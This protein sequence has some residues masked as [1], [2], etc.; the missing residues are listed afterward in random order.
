MI[1][2]RGVAGGGDEG[3]ELWC[4]DLKVAVCG[5]V[6]IEYSEESDARVLE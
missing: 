5:L 4:V 3:R 2:D 1:S 6:V